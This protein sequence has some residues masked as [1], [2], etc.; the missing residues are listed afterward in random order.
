MPVPRRA[1]ILLSARTVG[2]DQRIEATD[3]EEALMLAVGLT[4]DASHAN[5]CQD[6]SG[7]APRQ[8]AAAAYL[9]NA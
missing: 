6:S 9:G 8:S 3:I 1:G 7:P 5:E 4:A 2:F